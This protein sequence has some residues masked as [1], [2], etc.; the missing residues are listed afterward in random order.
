MLN[1]LIDEMAAR[2]VWFRVS[3]NNVTAEFDKE[4][5]LQ[6]YG[7]EDLWDHLCTSYIAT[8]DYMGGFSFGVMKEIFRLLKNEG[9]VPVYLL[10]HPNS[11][12]KGTVE[13]LD[14]NISTLVGIQFLGMAVVENEAIDEDGFVIAAGHSPEASVH[15]IVL[16]VK[17]QVQ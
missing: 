6:G 16:G 9:L 17:G 7:D 2:V 12:L 8:Y 14:M 13:W 4:V 11:T 5:E 10:I 3:R 1:W 15:N